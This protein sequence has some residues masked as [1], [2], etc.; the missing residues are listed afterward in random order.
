VARYFDAPPLPHRTED[1]EAAEEEAALDAAGL[2][3]RSRRHGR[4]ALRA[5]RD[6]FLE[7]LAGA[8]A[9]GRARGSGGSSAAAG[10]GRRG[11]G[12]AG[13][14]MASVR[15]DGDDA[16]AMRMRMTRL[17]MWLQTSLLTA[18][19]LARTAMRSMR[20]AQRA[21]G[22]GGAHQRRQARCE[23]VTRALACVHHLLLP[24]LTLFFHLIQRWMP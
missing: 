11:R 21:E 23:S 24:P 18:R 3:L 17:R 4:E 8:N 6:I 14:D 10:G 7:V 2:G 1:E 19:L 20:T 16:D 5:A 15:G 22:A 12:S 9:G 13:D